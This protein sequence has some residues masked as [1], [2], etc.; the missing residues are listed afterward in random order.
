MTASISEICR[1][2]AA[3][4]LPDAFQKALNSY[5]AFMNQEIPTDKVKTFSD[6]HNA[7]KI[8]IAHLKLLLLFAREIDLPDPKA[9]N[10][11]DQILLAAVIQE[12]EEELRL[13]R[14]QDNE[15][16]LQEG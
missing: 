7:G 3:H 6:H 11:N 12:A 5:Q 2:Q 1:Q 10:H 4:F 9:G 8:A 13:Y 16:L 14:E 15:D